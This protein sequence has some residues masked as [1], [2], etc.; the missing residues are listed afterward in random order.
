VSKIQ[1]AISMDTLEV[2]SILPSF[3]PALEYHK[4]SLGAQ[5]LS[6]CQFSV[7]PYTQKNYCSIK[8][9]RKECQYMSPCPHRSK[10]MLTQKKMIERYLDVDSRTFL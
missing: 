8:D 6:N 3:P 5:D 2:D 4:P 9:Q 7:Y 1:I 10:Y